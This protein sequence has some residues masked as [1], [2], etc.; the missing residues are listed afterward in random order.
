MAMGK[1]R[2]RS[3]KTGTRA[4]IKNKRIN[5]TRRGSNARLRPQSNAVA[6]QVL[7]QPEIKY[8]LWVNIL[9]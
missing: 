6:T 2:R 4:P 3:I 9:T 1:P 5:R 8:P 7:T